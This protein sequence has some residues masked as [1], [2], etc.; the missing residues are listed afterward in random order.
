MSDSRRLTSLAL[1]EKPVVRC[2][3]MRDAFAARLVSPADMQ[4]GC[5]CR[6]PA[7]ISGM[8]LP[9]QRPCV[10]LASI[11]TG[12]VRGPTLQNGGRLMRALVRPAEGKCTHTKGTA[13]DVHVKYSHHHHHHHQIRQSY[14]CITAEMSVRKSPNAAAMRPG[15]RRTDGHG[16]TCSG[17]GWR[18]SN[19]SAGGRKRQRECH[20]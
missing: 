10:A 9:D 12:K 17:E 13:A 15:R 1:G 11:R 4:I 20:V 14:L 16:R 2:F 8:Y 6:S 18:A 5:L 19:R 3:D 7:F